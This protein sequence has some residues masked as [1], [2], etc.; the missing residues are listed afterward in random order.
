MMIRMLA[1]TAII[2][3]VTLAAA[4]TGFAKGHDQGF[5]AQ[6]AGKATAGAV[7]EGQSNRDDSTFGGN[8]SE[9]AYGKR[10][11]SVEAKLGEQ[12]NS[13]VARDRAWATHPSN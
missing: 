10:D 8:G 9:T 3:A 7:D 6:L 12:D 11:A 13:E 2:S 5:G 1:T 4:T